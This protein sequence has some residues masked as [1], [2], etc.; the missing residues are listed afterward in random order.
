[1]NKTAVLITMIAVSLNIYGT[2]TIYGSPDDND[3]RPAKLNDI[4]TIESVELIDCSDPEFDWSQFDEKYGKALVTK[5]G[6]ELESRKN[7][8]YCI[9]YFEAE[10]LNLESDDFIIRFIMTPKKISN[11]KPF[12]II[13]DVENEKNYKALLL[14]EKNFQRIKVYD[15]QFAIEK[16]DIYKRLSKQKSI[17][18]DLV[19]ERGKLHCIINKL[20]LD[21]IKNKKLTN[22]QFGFIVGPNCEMLCEKIGF[23]KFTRPEEDEAYS[24]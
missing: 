17:E 5:K 21:I 20:E 15:G 24:K 22:P 3:N 2:P 13:Y 11:D 12:G 16:K 1:M 8:M 7:D 19:M 9:T 4:K 14:F 18:V 23:K 6:F 10:K